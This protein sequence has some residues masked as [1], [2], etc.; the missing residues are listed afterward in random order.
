MNNNPGQTNMLLSICRNLYS[1]YNTTTNSNY[2]LSLSTILSYKVSTLVSI[3]TINNS[4]IMSQI[5][6]V[7]PK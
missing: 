3:A 7:T 2:K 4:N 6:G 5:A 1:D